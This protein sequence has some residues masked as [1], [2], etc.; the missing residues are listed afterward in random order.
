VDDDGLASALAAGDAIELGRIVTED[1]DVLRHEV[2]GTGLAPLCAACLS[3]GLAPGSPVAPGLVEC[4]EV[5]LASGADP[6]QACQTADGPVLPLAAAA[7][8]PQAA[9]LLRDAGARER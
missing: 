3:P 6:N 5:L 4:I 9:R 7:R 8:N 1:P 2:R